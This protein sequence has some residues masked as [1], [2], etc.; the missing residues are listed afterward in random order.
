M[1]EELAQ[2]DFD[3]KSVFVLRGK[4][5]PFSDGGELI[6]FVEMSRKE[7]IVGWGYQDG[8]VMHYP[9][10]QAAWD[11]LTQNWGAIHLF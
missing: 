4:Y 5:S 6:I 2:G 8:S 9:C 7:G 11:D 1:L 3:K 10:L